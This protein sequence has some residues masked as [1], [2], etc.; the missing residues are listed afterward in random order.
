M[1][2]TTLTM[3]PSDLVAE[4][5]LGSSLWALMAHIGFSEVE[6][7]SLATKLGMPSEQEALQAV[8]PRLLASMPEDDFL[9]ATADTEGLSTFFGKAKIRTLLQMAIGLTRTVIEPEVKAPPAPGTP[10]GFVPGGPLGGGVLKRGKVR[11]RVGNRVAAQ[12]GHGQSWPL[13]PRLNRRCTHRRFH[14]LGL[15]RPRCLHHQVPHQ[16]SLCNRL[17]P[18]GSSR[19]AT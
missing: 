9:A 2:A 1:A 17:H 15:G 16:A 19:R 11:H 14:S 4:L 5:G 6:A 12:R 3:P 7:K 10:P 13:C 18:Q 8:H